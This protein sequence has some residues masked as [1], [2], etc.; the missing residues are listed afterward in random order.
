[1]WCSRMWG[2]CFA[3]GVCGKGAMSP[4]LRTRQP[5]NDFLA[6]MW[7]AEIGTLLD[8][9]FCAGGLGVTPGSEAGGC[10]FSPHGHLVGGSRLL[11]MA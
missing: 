4:E 7:S 10:S 5:L 1:M 8:S 9:Q 2:S 11:Q 6:S 3:G